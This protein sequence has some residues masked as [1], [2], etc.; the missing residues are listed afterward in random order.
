MAEEKPELIEVQYPL[1]GEMP[2][3]YCPIC[4][5]ALIMHTKPCATPTTFYL[6]VTQR[7]WLNETGD[8]VTYATDGREFINRETAIRWATGDHGH[9]D[10]NIA[11]VTD[12]RLVAFGWGMDD[13]PLDE[14]G[15]PHGHDLREIAEQIGLEVT[16]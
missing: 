8:G 14:D 9:D 7:L 1:P 16:A 4:E 2:T 10:F 6:V 5:L 3:G 11:T 15:C 13:F 12:G